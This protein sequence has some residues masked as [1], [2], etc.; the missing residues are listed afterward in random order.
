MHHAGIKAFQQDVLA[1]PVIPS[2]SSHH[3]PQAEDRSYAT[4]QHSAWLSPS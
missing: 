2:G 4:P 1:E 3:Y